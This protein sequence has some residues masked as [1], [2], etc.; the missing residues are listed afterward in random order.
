MDEVF[1]KA[2]VLSFHTPLTDETRGLV[3]KDFLSKFRKPIF[4]LNGSRG[5]VVDVEAVI[6]G[7]E[8]KSILGACFDVLPKEKFPALYETS[9]YGKLIKF[10][11]VILTPHVA[12]WSVES[13][14]K[15][16]KFLAEK[17]LAYF[18][19]LETVK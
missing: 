8:R 19:G 5:E 2:D 11:N 16:S 6:E 13:Y 3:S 10:D 1:V 12:G 7:L 18:K 15:L 14:F 4:L 9:W 17:V